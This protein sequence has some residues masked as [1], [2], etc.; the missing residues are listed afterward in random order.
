MGGGWV[1]GDMDKD[2]LDW[3]GEKLNQNTITANPHTLKQ[4][5]LRPSSYH[6]DTSECQKPI[7]SPESR[8]WLRHHKAEGP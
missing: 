3:D 5:F 2:G 1:V 4:H 8:P 7:A 6:E